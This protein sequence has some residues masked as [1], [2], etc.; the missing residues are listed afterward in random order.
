VELWARNC[1][2]ILPKLRLP[3]KSRDLLHAANLRRG[4]DGFTSTP[5]E[6]VLRIMYSNKY[7]LCWRISVILLYTSNILRLWNRCI[8]SPSSEGFSSA[9][10]ECNRLFNTLNH[11]AP[12][13]CPSYCI[14]NRR[15]RFETEPVSE[16]YSVQCCRTG[17]QVQKLGHLNAVPWA[18]PFKSDWPLHSCFRCSVLCSAAWYRVCVVKLTGSLLQVDRT[19]AEVPSV[20][21]LH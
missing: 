10:S 3:R 20:S 14:P 18:W 11:R 9:F 6:G 12:K 2:V 15:R 16:V 8:L 1:P 21:Y 7:L 13:L 5:K 4:T 17:G 19:V